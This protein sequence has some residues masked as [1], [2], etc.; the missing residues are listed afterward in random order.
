MPVQTEGDYSPIDHKRSSSNM[1][2]GPKNGQGYVYHNPI[3]N[4]LPYNVQNPYISK[5]G[6]GHGQGHGQSPS[7]SPK[8]NVL[9]NVAQQSIIAGN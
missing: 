4:P 6:N 9:A 5:V 1:I 3:T 7:Q 8:R 2:P